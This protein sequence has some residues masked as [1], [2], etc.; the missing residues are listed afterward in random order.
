MK[1]KYLHKITDMTEDKQSDKSW[2][3]CSLQAEA[4]EKLLQLLELRKPLDPN[5]VVRAFLALGLEGCAHPFWKGG[6]LY[7]ETDRLW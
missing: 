2:S 5:S 4:Q 3:R 6:E 7:F 1:K